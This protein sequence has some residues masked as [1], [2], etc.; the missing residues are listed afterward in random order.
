[1]IGRS[2]HA[3]AARS[4]L[5]APRRRM[6]AAESHILPEIGM[7]GGQRRSV[8]VGLQPC[9]PHLCAP[10]FPDALDVGAKRR[11]EAVLFEN[12]TASLFATSAPQ[13][14]AGQSMPI[15]QSTADTQPSPPT[16]SEAPKGDEIATNLK[17]ADQSQT[18][19]S[20]S[21]AEALLNQSQAWAE[22]ARVPVR[23]VQGPQVQVVQTVPERI[24]PVQKQQQVRPVQ[25]AKVVKHARAKVRPEQNA[26]AQGG[27]VQMPKHRSRGSCKAP[28]ASSKYP[29][30]EP[31]ALGIGPLE[32]AIRG[33][34][35]TLHALAT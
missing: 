3:A 11:T 29:P 16:A 25:R 9:R 30:A 21:S 17:T 19:V 8:A 35:A 34:D 22:D 20:Q 15:I 28:V 24:R 6:S 33:A 23:P 12:A 2:G 4:S 5:S 32:A 7:I 31:G 13:D 10:P 26:Q 27:S 14:G 1:L 18:D